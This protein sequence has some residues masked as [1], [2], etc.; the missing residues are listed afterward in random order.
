MLEVSRL[1][2]FYGQSHIL[3]AIDLHLSAGESV[4]LLGRNGAG[5]ST[6]LKALMDA[7]PRARGDIVL[8]GSP[9]GPDATHARARRG[10]SLVPEDRRIFPKLTVAQNIEMGCYAAAAGR[11][12]YTLDEVVALLPMVAPLLDRLGYQLSG[13]QQQMIAIA[14]G[15]VSRPN[16]LMLDEP[17]E[18]LAP[19]IV[20]ELSDA[21]N[22]V[23][24]TEGM[25]MIITEQ[26]LDFARETTDRLYLL[27]VGRVV[28]A[29]T[30][31]EFDDRADLVDRYLA[32]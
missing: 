18:G 3:H 6:F 4:A 9:L 1:D 14:R 8:D 23:R 25:A 10:M 2:A 30:W 29:G 11:S 17:A 15:I 7:G 21:V 27:D 24:R 16:V 20:D 5:K 19:V 22:R 12:C 32:L 31:A 13:G 28:F 26:N